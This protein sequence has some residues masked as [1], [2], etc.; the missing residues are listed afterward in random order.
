MLVTIV[1]TNRRNSHS[2]PMMKTKKIPQNT[3][4]ANISLWWD[5]GISFVTF[6]IYVCMHS[7]LP[8]R[9]T[10]IQSVFHSYPVR[11]LDAIL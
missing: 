1:Y 7:Q 9:K 4:T 5:L 3:G 10:A 2:N 11:V 6:Y 8:M